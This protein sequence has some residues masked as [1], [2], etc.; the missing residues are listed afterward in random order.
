M[1]PRI[2]VSVGDLNGVGIEIA[3]KAHKEIS[4]LCTPIY[5]I[6]AYML[7][8]AAELLD[9]KI[10]SDFKIFDIKGTFNIR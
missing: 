9:V 3:L 5:C 6:N 1:K 4:A 7:N 2:A 10:P 8:Q